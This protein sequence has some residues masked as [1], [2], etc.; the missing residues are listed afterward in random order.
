MQNNVREK[1][2]GRSPVK[3]ITQAGR[4]KTKKS[5]IKKHEPDGG[6][7]TRGGRDSG[8]KIECQEEG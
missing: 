8:E 4:E 1:K 3:Q 7:V 2:G 5:K 6:C